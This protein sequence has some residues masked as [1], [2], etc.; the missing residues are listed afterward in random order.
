MY[1]IINNLRLDVYPMT[2]GKFRLCLSYA[3]DEYSIMD[4]W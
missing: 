4:S 3:D 1:K 2:F